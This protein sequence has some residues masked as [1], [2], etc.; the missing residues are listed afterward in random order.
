M[1]AGRFRVV[2]L[3]AHGGMGEVYEATDDHLQQKR[4]AIKTLRSDLARNPSFRQRFEREVLLAREVHHPNVCPTYDL[5]NVSDEHGPLTFLT[6]KLLRGESLHSRIRREHGLPPETVQSLATQIAAALDAAHARGVVHRDLKPGN[7]MLE[8]SSTGTLVSV[9]DFGL[10]RAFDAVD[11]IAPGQILGTPGYMAPEIMR[12][13]TAGFP[14]DVYAFGIVV[15][16]MLTGRRPDDPL[17]PKPPSHIVAGLDPY[18]DKVVHGCLSPHP[19][20]RFRSAGEALALGPR[21]TG[22]LPQGRTRR[23]LPIKAVAAAAAILAIVTAGWAARVNWDRFAN[24]LPEKRYVALMAWPVDANAAHQPLLRTAIDAIGSRL[25]RAESSTNELMIIS[26]SDIGGSPA[27]KAPTDATAALGANLVLTTALEETNGRVTVHLAVVDATSG[28]EI[29]RRSES[30]TSDQLPKLS[31][32]VA[33][34]AAQ[35]LDLPLPT[36]AWK[37]QDEIASLPPSAFALLTEA[38]ELFARPNDTGLEEAIVKYQLLVDSQPKFA[39]GY[40]KLAGAYGRKHDKA[41]D[42]A[43]LTLA[44]RNADLALRYNPDSVSATLSRATAHLYSGNVEGALS[45]L[46][47]ALQLDPANP[48][49]LVV[50]AQ[51]LRTLDRPRDEEAVYREI[52][53]NRPN[54]WPAYSQLGLCLYRQA[55]YEEASRAFQEGIVVAPRVVSLLNNLGAMQILMQ[56]HD[57]AMNTYRLS[58]QATPTST[59]YQ[60][61]GTLAFRTGDYAKALDFYGRARELSPRGELIL[62][63]LADTY[64]VMG[65]AQQASE[66]YRAGA[67]VVRDMLDI[68]PNRGALWMTFAYYQAKLGKTPEAKAALARAEELGASDMPSQLKRVQ[69]MLRLGLAEQALQLL[70]ELRRKGLSEEDVDLAIDL[71]ELRKNARYLAL[72]QTKSP[73]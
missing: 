9:T 73:A 24:P 33:T 67:Q 6:M 36:G 44:E 11:T 23:R 37:D 48:Q 55:R 60:N 18:W 22:P 30:I 45:G 25:S 69:I 13:Q 10:S 42:R 50:K 72:N 15:Y 68:N 35:L 19:D 52:L 3:L 41:P 46:D 27:L 65:E 34:A 17:F 62:R 56:R 59:A 70:I 51:A 1:L 14:V 43:V 64:V 2:Q 26:A 20:H 38:D 61:L 28:R 4:H 32:T 12:G 7:I 40:A 39:L 5:F 57:E 21:E 58:V 63:N 47:R 16:E 66:T 8:E 29:R 49:V 53:R 31:M 71:R 54:F